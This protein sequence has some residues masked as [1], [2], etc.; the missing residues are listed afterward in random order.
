MD[1]ELVT[2]I[3]TNL[4]KAYG[5]WKEY[6][7]PACNPVPY[8]D[9]MNSI[10]EIFDVSDDTYL[11]YDV[12][13]RYYLRIGLGVWELRLSM[14]GPYAYLCRISTS[15]SVEVITDWMQVTCPEELTLLE[16]LRT[17]GIKPLGVE[18]LSYP[19]PLVLDDWEQDDVRV[20]HGLFC[21]VKGLPWDFVESDDH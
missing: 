6:T 13:Y 20:F 19:I 9:L 4:L 12:S 7:S 18:E 5:D 2:E 16:L 10:E 11:N 15:L 21:H 17:H 8:T 14:A 3:L 1:H